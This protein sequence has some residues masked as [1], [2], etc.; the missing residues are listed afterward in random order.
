M[1]APRAAGE[2]SLTSSR[3]LD[4][5]C[6]QSTPMTTVSM[7]GTAACSI[8]HRK[9]PAYVTIPQ[10]GITVRTIDAPIPRRTIRDRFR[11]LPRRTCARRWQRDRLRVMPVFMVDWRSRKSPNTTGRSQLQL[12]PTAFV[13]N[14]Q[15]VPIVTEN[16]N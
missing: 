7:P 9:T 1:S 11:A 2:S 3:L 4:L 15:T 6:E 10:I 14:G 8:L 5:A 12:E 13:V 16:I